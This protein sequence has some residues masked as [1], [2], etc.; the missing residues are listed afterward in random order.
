MIFTR[1]YGNGNYTFCM[2]ILVDGGSIQLLFGAGVEGLDA[3]RADARVWEGPARL[4][5][6]ICASLG[7]PSAAGTHFA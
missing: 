4:C 5:D 1:A 6:E 2:A 7:P 3:C